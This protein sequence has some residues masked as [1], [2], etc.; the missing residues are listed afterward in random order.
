MVGADGE[1]HELFECHAI[2]GVDLEQG[3]RDGSE[4]QALLHDI[5]ADEEGGGDGFLGHALVAH[6]L[7]GAELVERMQRR[8]LHVL[9][10]RDLVDQDVAVGVADDAGHRR[11][12]GQALLLR[13]QFEGTIAAATGGHLEHAAL[14]AIGVEDGTDMEALDETAPGDGLGQLLDRDAGLDAPNIGLAQHQ[15]VEGDVAR[16]RQGDLLNGSRHV[17]YSATGGREPLSRPPTRHE[18]KRRPLT[19]GGQRQAGGKA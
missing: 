13:E 1:G 9:D 10:Q 5:D 14:G 3:R 19:L 12:L 4:A 11:G 6:G 7:E 16:R 17:R 18:A 2:L 8:A 15:L